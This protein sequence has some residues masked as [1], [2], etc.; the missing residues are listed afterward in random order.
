MQIIRTKYKQYLTPKKACFFE[1][2]DKYILN[3]NEVSG[4]E[5]IYV[6]AIVIGEDDQTYIT[7]FVEHKICD[8]NDP[9]YGDTVLIPLGFHKTRFVK[10]LLEP[11]V[12]DEEEYLSVNGAGRQGIGDPALHKN[13][14]NNS[15]AAWAK[16]VQAQ[17][18]RDLELIKR[19]EVLRMEYR[20]KVE[21]G[22][23]RPPTRIE[24]LQK[25][26]S[27]NPDNASVSAAIRLL[28]K[29]GLR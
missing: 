10:W 5:K 21:R 17:A 28:E 2:G 12:I 20:L 13:R 26:A 7:R 6:E 15:E 11:I 4:W 24:R 27:G 14:G 25:I 18:E 19:R 16:I 8:A 29:H 23:L 9:K 3:K 22:E 1:T